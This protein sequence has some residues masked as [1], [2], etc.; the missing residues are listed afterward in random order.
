MRYKKA[1]FSLVTV[2]GI[3]IA[4]L[5]TILLF[6]ASVEAQAQRTQPGP[7]IQLNKS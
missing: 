7:R 1:V 4:L 3:L 6:I 2:K 5:L